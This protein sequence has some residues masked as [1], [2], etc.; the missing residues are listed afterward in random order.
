MDLIRILEKTLST[1]SNLTW[2]GLKAVNE[3]L[4][5]K[6]FQPYWAHA[7]LPKSQ[8]R[9]KPPLGLPRET[10]SLCPHCVRELRDDIQADRINWQDVIKT[11]P[12]M[13]KARIYEDDGKVLMEKTCERHGRCEDLIAIDKEFFLH[14]ESLFM[15]DDMPIPQN[16]LRN[17]GASSI[18]YSRG[19]C[20]NV[21]LTNRC[22]MMCRPCYMDANQVG[23]VHEL[24][25]DDVRK[26]LTDAANFKP[27]RQTAVMFA[28]GEPTISP[29][30]LESCTIARE[31]GFFSVQAATNGLRFA[32]EPGFAEKAKDAGLRIAY[33]QFDG[34]G[35][36]SHAHRKIANLFD[37]KQRIIENC[38]KAGI[39]VMIVPTIV[40]TINNDQVGPILDFAINNVGTIA[41][42]AFQ[43]VSFTGRDD[44]I[45]DDQR[46]RERYTTSHLAHEISKYTDGVIDPM[47][48]WFPLSALAPFA[49]A[50]DLTR[51][52]DDSWGSMKCGC[53]PNCGAGFVLLVNKQTREVVPVTKIV[54]FKQLLRDMLDIADNYRGPKWAKAQMA[55]SLMRNYR[56]DEAPKGLDFRK[57]VNIFLE[58]SGAKNFGTPTD[59]EFDWGV[60]FIAAMWFQD[61]Y[62]YDFRRTERCVIP[63]GTQMGEISFCAY[64]TGIG[65]RWIVEK[66]FQNATTKE[67]FKANGRHPIY[68]NSKPIDLPEYETPVDLQGNPVQWKGRL[69]KV[70]TPQS[71]NGKDESIPEGVS[72]T[73]QY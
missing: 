44:N 71:I 28:G 62:N 34:I 6:P 52:M 65:W 55:L 57:L 39:N 5:T 22:N 24:T 49:D 47:R 46:R 41:G 43:P 3:F 61:V 58:Q 23:Y 30:F 27:R 40:N 25:V 60:M 1:S 11:N 4:P 33:L 72:V 53:H 42:I 13:V 18:K 68:A 7:P 14:M 8:K 36:Q 35:N 32:L 45:P 69:S 67:W 17:H 9:T 73:T 26:I 59:P 63:Y 21:D 51:G 16:M 31:L 54:N 19:A 48:D 38:R 70:K 66:E 64:N 20:L 29:I 2:K 15:G 56:P 50:V 12:G 10:D 37:V